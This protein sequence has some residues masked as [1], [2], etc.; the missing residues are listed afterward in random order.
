VLLVPSP[1]PCGERVRVRG[2]LLS[3]CDVLSETCPMS[4]NSV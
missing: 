4:E 2:F 3:S 1:R